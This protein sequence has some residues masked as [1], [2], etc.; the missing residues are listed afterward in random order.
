MA[1]TDKKCTSKC[2][3]LCIPFFYSTATSIN[4]VLCIKDFSGFMGR[5]NSEYHCPFKAEIRGSNP[6]GG[7]NFKRQ[8]PDMRRC[9]FVK[10]S[11]L[12]P[13]VRLP[14][15]SPKTNY[16]FPA[17]SYLFIES[18][19]FYGS[20]EAA[21]FHIYPAYR[22]RVMAHFA[23]NKLP[24][25]FSRGNFISSIAAIVLPEINI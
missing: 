12:A 25:G 13:L 11:F 2:T 24:R 10:S 9:F 18:F 7:A 1:N 5:Y 21:R 20:A 14:Q 4:K 6:L 22:P 15:H 3:L 17:F 8:P 23:C 19:G 16:L